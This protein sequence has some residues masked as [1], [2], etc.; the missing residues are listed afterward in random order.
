MKNNLK[1]AQNALGNIPW[2]LTG[3]TAMK[4]YGNKYGIETRK[5]QNV[6]I[7]VKETFKMHIILFTDLQLR[8]VHL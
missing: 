6:N 4:L 2:A 5:P 7:T 3:S 1:K 8:T